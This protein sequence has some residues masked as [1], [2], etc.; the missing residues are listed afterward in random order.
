MREPR[1]KDYDFVMVNSS[2]GKDSQTALAEVVRLA[3]T[4][5]YDRKRIIV[6]HA[7]LGESEWKGV[8]DLAAAQAK[9][10]GLEFHVVKR[11]DQ[12]GHEETLLEYVERRKMWPSSTTRYCTSDFKRGPCQRMITELGRRALA[13]KA[14]LYGNRPYVA[15]AKILSVFGFR[16][17]ESPARAKRPKFSYNKRASS[18]KREVWDW[19]PIHDWEEHEVWADIN[20]SGVPYHEAYDLGMPRLSCVFCVFAPDH[21]LKIAGRANPELLTKYVELE[22]KIGHDFKKGSPIAAIQKELAREEYGKSM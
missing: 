6:C 21:A 9:H 19:S 11:R 10:Y 17:E 15:I 2:G 1:L 16:A 7:D 5:G 13:K 3:N 18:Q 4:Q 20:R 14:A 22:K 12:H 8:K